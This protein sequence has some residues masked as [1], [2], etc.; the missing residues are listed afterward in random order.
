MKRKLFTFILLWL[1]IIGTAG[2]LSKP[3]DSSGDLSEDLG[4]R[5][6]VET[7]TQ[8]AVQNRTNN[9][10]LR[11]ETISPKPTSAEK[12]DLDMDIEY[13]TFGIKGELRA[14]AF[15]EELP[16]DAVLIES[17]DPRIAGLEP[18][19]S[20][21]EASSTSGGK[22]KDSDTLEGEVLK[23]HMRAWG[24]ILGTSD[25]TPG[26]AIYVRHEGSIYLV[27][28]MYLGGATPGGWVQAE[29]VEN[30]S[31]DS[32][33]VNSSHGELGNST[34]LGALFDRAVKN[35]SAKSEYFRGNDF[36]ELWRPLNELPGEYVQHQGE[37]LRIEI[38]VEA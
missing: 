2:C 19:H 25:P 32:K 21:L 24:S 10:T 5:T 37:I 15:E 30:I 4:E 26:G 18:F 8:E 3:D 36:K 33:V 27:G 14:F 7:P 23:E 38:F 12:G 6:P 20:V 22:K 13:D 34:V 16:E 29:V 9:D 17:D 28:L 35:G 1:V 31:G 11:G